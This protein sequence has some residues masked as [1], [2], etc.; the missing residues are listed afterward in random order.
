MAQVFPHLASSP[1][2]TAQ[3]DIISLEGTLRTHLFAFPPVSAPT[4]D[5][6]I[7]FADIY[8]VGSESKEKELE[9]SQPFVHGVK[10]HGPKG[11]IDRL[12]GVFDDGAMINAMD[13]RVFEKIE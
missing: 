13:S 7:H 5:H 1:S 12:K 6:I 10:L 3:P 4:N 9:D 8:T 11:E 2:Q